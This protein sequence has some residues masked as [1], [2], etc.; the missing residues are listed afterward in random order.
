MKVYYQEMRNMDFRFNHLFCY[1]SCISCSTV[2][3]QTWL[4]QLTAVTAYTD[5]L[6]LAGSSCMCNC[7][8]QLA[9]YTS[10]TQLAILWLTVVATGQ[11]FSWEQLSWHLNSGSSR[12]ALF[13]HL[14]SFGV[15]AIVV[16]MHLLLLCRLC[17]W[18]YTLDF[19]CQHKFVVFFLLNFN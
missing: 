16:F 4:Q 15:V 18:L 5:V 2:A 7:G 1:R 9:N 13:I 11:L 17:T 8:L 3:V 12:V 14:T 19:E 6:Q 10:W